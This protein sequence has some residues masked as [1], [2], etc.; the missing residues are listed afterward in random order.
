MKERLMRAYFTEGAAVGNTETLVSLATEIGVDAER[1][2][3]VLT[4]DEYADEVRADEQEAAEI[5]VSGVPFFVIDRRY[6]I[7]GAQPAELFDQALSQA[8]AD[9][10]PLVQIG[11]EAEACADGS[12]EIPARG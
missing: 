4:S 1:A 11:G 2:R 10:H 8:W 5:G 9:A 3:A 12:C 7:S 6:G